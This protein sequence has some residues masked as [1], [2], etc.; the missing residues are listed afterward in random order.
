MKTDE[1]V[2]TLEQLHQSKMKL[3]SMTQASKKM[4]VSHEHNQHVCMDGTWLMISPPSY[5][6]CVGVNDNGERMFTLGRMTFD[7]FQPSDL[8]CSI[9]KQYNTIRTVTSEEK[10]PAY[11]PPS[12]RQEAENE[13]KKKHCGR[14]KAHK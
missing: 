2:E 6:A 9:Q 12:L 7:M 3:R 5:P 8:V 4:K 13:H 14:L 10:L 1:A 11:I